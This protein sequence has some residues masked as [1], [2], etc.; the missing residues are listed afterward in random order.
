VG[1]LSGRK[2][3]L[4]GSYNKNMVEE[5]EANNE[6]EFER[7]EDGTDLRGYELDSRL[8]LIVDDEDEEEETVF[9][10]RDTVSE[11]F[12]SHIDR[13][14]LGKKVLQVRYAVKDFDGYEEIWDE[15]NELI[16]LKELEDEKKDN[17]TAMQTLSKL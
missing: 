17:L 16:D 14:E 3:I 11:L 2:Y 12:G 1:I 10:S 5:F 7:T 15:R 8:V 6:A 4:F 9:Y 13:M